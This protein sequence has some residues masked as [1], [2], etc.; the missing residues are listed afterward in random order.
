MY[1][2]YRYK[3]TD[4]L[5][6]QA[7]QLEMLSV[8][9]SET[10]NVV[11]I[12]DKE[13]NYEWLNNGFVKLYEYTLEEFIRLVGKNIKLTSTD[14]RI[15]EYV[16]KCV[17]DVVTVTYSSLCYNRSGKKIWLQTSLSP[18][19]DETGEVVK[20]VAIESNVTAIILA[21]KEVNKK[22]KE[23][24]L[25]FD[26][27]KKSEEEI[28][29][30]TV[31][32][33]KLSIVASRTDS[34]VIIMDSYGTIEW[35][36]DEVMRMSDQTIR[37]SILNGSTTIF[38]ISVAQNIE[39]I[40]NE[41]KE[42]KKS[43]VYSTQCYSKQGERIWSQTTLTP[44]LDDAGNISRI[45]ALD[46]DI[47][48]IKLAE[49][50][51]KEKN[52]QLN[53]AY[54]K[55]KIS[56]NDLKEL[57]A[58]KDKFFSIIAHDL[59]APFTS[60]I[61]VSELLADENSGLDEKKKRYLARSIYQSAASI[62]NLLEN[63]LLWSRSQTG[64]IEI[65]PKEIN[66]STIVLSSI[67][68]F[69]ENAAAKSINLISEVD[70]DTYAY[71]DINLTTTILRNLISN[72]IKFCNEEGDVIINAKEN[73]DFLE[74]SVLDSGIGISKSDQNKLFRIDTD[75]TTIGSSLEK[76]TGLGLVIC[77]EFVREIGGKIW[78]ESELNKGSIFTFTIPNL[79]NTI[80]NEKD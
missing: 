67:D 55:L 75:N 15:E 78:V 79:T 70:I 29:A 8:V 42:K 1:Y 58:T 72:A 7:A 53:I 14:D 12:M 30:Q 43:I 37:E 36:N 71:A 61:N 50:E 28:K 34:A 48:S 32:L 54:E 76:G 57:V 74:V 26:K 24:K 4:K 62:Y 69:R 52:R 38:D 21:E 27:L 47:N 77:T 41:C 45:V 39:D 20:I 25:A 60:F 13:G 5:R 6:K 73:N 64:K 56:E 23:L 51:I 44:I 10:D 66:I 33:E 68:L 31:E 2:K 9:A 49:G 63:L 18:V 40:F 11:M 16:N 59:K 22:N 35:V 46:S 80:N 19:K 17:N 65:T 3:V